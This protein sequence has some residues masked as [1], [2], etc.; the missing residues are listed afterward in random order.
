MAYV[1]NLNFNL[2]SIKS[3]ASCYFYYS[4][5]LSQV[6][7]P[8]LNLN[9]SCFSVKILEPIIC[10]VIRNIAIKVSIIAFVYIV[11]RDEGIH[12]LH[13]ELKPVAF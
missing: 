9:K 10:G 13:K 1:R 7:V 3:I 12:G 4:I 2:N 8:K 6:F 5:P 11:N